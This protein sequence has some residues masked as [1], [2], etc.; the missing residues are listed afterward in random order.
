MTELL[1]RKSALGRD[2]SSSW[3]CLTLTETESYWA[4]ERTSSSG[5]AAREKSGIFCISPLV[6]QS[7]PSFPVYHKRSFD[8]ED[9]RVDLTCF[10]NHRPDSLVGTLGQRQAAVGKSRGDGG[11]WSPFPGHWW[12]SGALWASPGREET[13]VES[14]LSC[15]VAFLLLLLLFSSNK[16]RWGMEMFLDWKGQSETALSFA[17]LIHCKYQVRICFLFM[18]LNLFTSRSDEV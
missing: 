1:I 6:S 9:E 5:K 17:L 14:L 10:G 15:P 11:E 13:R 8:Q 2:F 18:F 16:P 4:A 12:H 3:P 7:S